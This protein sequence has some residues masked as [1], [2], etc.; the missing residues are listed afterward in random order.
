MVVPFAFNRQTAL[1][2][3]PSGQGPFL[4]GRDPARALPAQG[5]ASPQKIFVRWVH[6]HKNIPY[7]APAAE[8]SRHGNEGQG[9]CERKRA[10][11]R[12][13]A[14]MK[15]VIEQRIDPSTPSQGFSQAGMP[16]RKLLFSAEKI[17]YSQKGSRAHGKL[18]TFF[19]Q[20][21]ITGAGILSIAGMRSGNRPRSRIKI[22]LFF[23]RRVLILMRC[24]LL[25][26]TE[27]AWLEG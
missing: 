7:G 6:D 18:P 14:F 20:L 24:S 15:T 16:I 9:P 27:Q 10:W 13:A 4:G 23:G 12:S 21:A 2:P 17:H 22:G 25:V 26:R 19:H 5:W 1:Y 11:Q 8:N 3:A